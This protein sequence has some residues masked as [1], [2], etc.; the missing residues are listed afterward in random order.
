MTARKKTSLL[1]ILVLVLLASTA[2][3]FAAPQA[4]APSPSPTSSSASGGDPAPTT[5]GGPRPTTSASST[6]T[7]AG[8]TTS[9]TVPTS[10]TAVS[11]A[12]Q[13]TNGNVAP[14]NIQLAVP[15]RGQ[16][17]RRCVRKEV[18]AM[19]TDEWNR[20]VAAVKQLNQGQGGGQ[21]TAYE[22]LVQEHLDY[23]PNAHGVDAFA[24]W[25][26]YFLARF[27][28]TLQKIDPSVC[29]P[30]WDWA[31]TSQ[32]YRAHP[33]FTPARL[34]SPRAGCITDGAFAGWNTRQSGGACVQHAWSPSRL[35][36]IQFVVG[37]MRG[38]P[39]YSEFRSRYEAQMHGNPHVAVG[40]IM[41]VMASPSSPMF[42]I[43][44]C[45]V[46]KHFQLYFEEINPGVKYPQPSEN[47]VPWNVPAG[48]LERTADWC[49]SYAD[50][51]FP[52]EVNPQ[53]P[54]GI[55]SA[56]LQMN[57]GGNATAIAAI[58]NST[59]G[60][61]DQVADKI[62]KNDTADLTVPRHNVG[63][64]FQPPAAA[65]SGA[66]MVGVSAVAVVVTAMAMLL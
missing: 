30:Y 13:P 22:K 19:T 61:L 35:A 24:M 2:A 59:A 57:F 21:M 64:A 4:P 62:A 23:T 6:S 25:H 44:H 1:A 37:L 45:A 53:Q 28:Q 7:A 63:S 31:R 41:S 60:V 36:A 51:P 58:T 52:D 20:Y 65:A 29:V 16:C 9:R 18:S 43:H 50:S 12:P 10:S 55:P 48:S 3:A 46:D 40:G 47:L 66:E 38:S 39:T 42:W 8:V 33:A 26:R 27:E 15:V 34:G 5:T 17:A 11:P 14:L 32:N 54:S 49:Y 56:W